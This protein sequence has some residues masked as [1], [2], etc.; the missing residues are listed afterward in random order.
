MGGGLELALATTFR[1]L[2]RTAT[3]GLPE[4]HLG[5]IPGAGG[6]YRLKK[7]IGETKALKM[8]LTGCKISGDLA[9]TWGLCEWL[10]SDNVQKLKP[11]HIETEGKAEDAL[12]EQIYDKSGEEVK[13]SS[14]ALKKAIT[15]AQ[16]I[17]RGGP[18]AVGAAL[19][20]VKAGN[21]NAEEKMYRICTGIGNRDRLEA[22]TA[23]KEKRD[24]QFRGAPSPKRQ[25]EK[26]LG[27]DREDAAVSRQEADANSSASKKMV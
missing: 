22:L 27:I 3:I 16:D 12:K 26:A 1:V 15:V 25:E 9:H 2:S 7:L 4:V 8:I 11:E 13:I 6:T 14:P 5:I 20:A 23:F 18:V 19:S 17:C 21:Q 24:P 10:A